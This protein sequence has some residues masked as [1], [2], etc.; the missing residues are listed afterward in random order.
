MIFFVQENDLAVC[1]DKFLQLDCT[2]K[3]DLRQ[4]FSTQ[5][6]ANVIVELIPEG[7][8]FHLDGMLIIFLSDGMPINISTN[9]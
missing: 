9:I 5:Y 8:Q 2:Q 3:I 7:W 1:I 4:R 6:L